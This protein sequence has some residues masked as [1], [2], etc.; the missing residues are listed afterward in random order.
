MS[1]DCPFHFTKPKHFALTGLDWVSRKLEQNGIYLTIV[2]VYQAMTNIL[3]LDLTVHPMG[4][5][6]FPVTG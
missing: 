3:R 6:H 2:S 4:Q 5:W 1:V